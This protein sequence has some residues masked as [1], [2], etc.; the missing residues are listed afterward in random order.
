MKTFPCWTQVEKLGVKMHKI[1][2]Q[3]VFADVL[4]LII[5]LGQLNTHCSYKRSRKCC[6]GAVTDPL[7]KFLKEFCAYLGIRR[8]DVLNV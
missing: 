3:D 2:S 7:A 4:N 8:K 1:V 6:N 5:S